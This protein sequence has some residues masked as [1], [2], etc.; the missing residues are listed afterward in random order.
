[1]CFNN[2]PFF[3]IFN[4]IIKNESYKEMIVIRWLIVHGYY[5][6]I[7]LRIVNYEWLL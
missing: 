1:M 4:I 5:D 6:I 2:L 3:R 7:L